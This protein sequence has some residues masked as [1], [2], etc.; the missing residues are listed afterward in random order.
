MFNLFIVG[1]FI[2]IIRSRLLQ[3]LC[4]TGGLVAAH[5]LKAANPA[6]VATTP[7]DEIC[8]L[9]LQAQ[10]SAND[11]E[12]KK[13]ELVKEKLAQELA[14]KGLTVTTT[15]SPD[16]LANSVVRGVLEVSKGLWVVVLSV[17]AVVLVISSVFIADLLLDAYVCQSYY[18][19]PII[20]SCWG[21]A[22]KLLKAGTIAARLSIWWHGIVG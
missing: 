13:M 17:G 20:P 12:I 19:L 8:K 1:G 7:A 22:D 9:S 10:L 16:T 6:T 11:L 21:S 4:L 2:M 3:I 18:Y 15:A 5:S 14:N